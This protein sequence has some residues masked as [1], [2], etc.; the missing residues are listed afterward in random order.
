VF[1]K[2]EKKKKKKSRAIAQ[3]NVGSKL[4]SNLG[5]HTNHGKNSSERLSHLKTL[6]S[7]C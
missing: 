6:I 4:C 5:M 2:K 1:E 3:E 7:L